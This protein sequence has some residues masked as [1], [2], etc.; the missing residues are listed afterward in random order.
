MGNVES[1]WKTIQCFYLSREAK[2]PQYRELIPLMDKE[3]GLEM[4]GQESG[5]I[6]KIPWEEVIREHIRTSD[7][8]D[9]GD[10]DKVGNEFIVVREGVVSIHLYYIPKSYIN[11]YDG[12]HYG[13]MYQ[14]FGKCQIRAK[15]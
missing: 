8:I 13:S 1:F 9:I 7:N 3:P 5:E 15:K 6:F 12:S 2:Y 4:R 14:W 11:P 10:V